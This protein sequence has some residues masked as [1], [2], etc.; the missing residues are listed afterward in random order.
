MSK[1]ELRADDRIAY[2]ISEATSAAGIRP[3]HLR[4]AL[5][6][7]EL[8]SHAVGRRTV[9]LQRRTCQFSS[10]PSRAQVI[11]VPAMRRRAMREVGRVKMFHP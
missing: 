2:G 3:H 6:S 8:Q 10:S 1:L 11:A 7:G 4:L 5:A 9:F